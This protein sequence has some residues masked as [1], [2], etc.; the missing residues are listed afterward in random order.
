V[1]EDEPNHFEHKGTIQ[2]LNCPI[3]DSI[4]A[5]ISDHLEVAS[6]WIEARR[7][8][9]CSVLVHCLGGISRSPTIVLGYM[10]KHQQMALHEAFEFV[11]RQ[12]RID[13]N[14]GFMRQLITFEIRYRGSPSIK[15]PPKLQFYG[16]GRASDRYEKKNKGK[17]RGKPQRG[18]KGR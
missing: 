6:D 2:Y 10:V 8:E 18:G 1:T 3:E 17:S 5:D 12:R 4:E 14:D 16:G 7:Q 15:L 13:P 11:L 9:G